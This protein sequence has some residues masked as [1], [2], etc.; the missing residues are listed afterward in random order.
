MNRLVFDI[1]KLQSIEPQQLNNSQT[2]F[3]QAQLNIQILATQ[4]QKVVII[5]SKRSTK[6][7][8][9]LQQLAPKAWKNLTAWLLFQKLGKSID[10]KNINLASQETQLQTLKVHV[11]E[12]K[13]KK[14]RKVERTDPNK[15]FATVADVIYTR[16]DMEPC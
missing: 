12:A 7:V 16:M 14:R 9:L 2:E 6:I 13:V 3:N 1:T 15:K 10:N 5:I 4:P 11:N 8:L